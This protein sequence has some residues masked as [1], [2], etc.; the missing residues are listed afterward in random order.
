MNLNAYRRNWLRWL[1]AYEKKSY[2]IMQSAFKDMGNQ[3]PF[4]KLTPSTYQMYIEATITIEEV[5]KAY[6]QIYYEIGVAHGVRMIKINEKQE[7]EITSDAFIEQYRKG[8]YEW[9]LQFAGIRITSVRNTYV[10]LIKELI[11]KGIQ[12]NLTMSEITTQIEKLI[13]SPTFYRWQAMRIARTESTTAANRAGFLVGKQS[14][15]IQ[16]KVWISATDNRTRRTPP[17]EYDHLEMN[18]VRVDEDEPFRL[19]DKWGV[20]EL[21]MYPGAVETIFDTPTHA[22]N[23]INCR[24]SH[25]M[26]PKEDANGNLI[27]R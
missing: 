9:V 10:E 27:R 22:G 4:N 13:N 8:L 19:K 23:I 2:K 3:I 1:K 5:A 17:N 14:K 11:A 18:K 6:E 25:A 24:C 26:V 15:F 16:Q 21:I 12:D 20:E 7:K